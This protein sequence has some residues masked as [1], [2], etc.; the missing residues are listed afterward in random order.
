[1]TFTQIREKRQERKALIGRAE[2]L[3]TAAREATRAMTP[4]EENQFDQMMNDGDTML[5]EIEREERLLDAREGL[6]R[7]PDGLRS[8]E[9]DPPEG[10]GGSE[11]YRQA[12]LGYLRHGIEG[13]EPAQ[14]AL[15]QA[16]F[17]ELP[18][19][20]RA[21]ST[22]VTTAGGFT[23]PEEFY[24]RLTEAQLAF[25]GM[26]QSR[27]TTLETASGADLPMP[28]NNDTANKGVIVSENAQVTEQDTTFGQKVLKA[29][30][31]SSKIVRVSYQLLQDSA[32]D[33][34]G[35]LA[36]ILGTRI[37]RATNEHFTV[38][39]GTTEPEGVVTGATL[40][41]TGT[42]GQTTSVTYNDLVDLFHS[43]DP[44]YR[45]NAQWMFDDSTLK[46]LKKLVDSQN[47]PLWTPGVAV[48]EPDTILGKPYIPNTD[49]PAMAADAKSI[50]F[51][52]LSL[53]MIRDVKGI[54]VLRLTERYADYLQVG[55]LAFSRHDGALLDAGTAPVKYYANSAT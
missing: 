51:G 48:R 7:T 23:V 41:K 35:F 55:F 11:E 22:G 17:G 29:F 21:L 8:A 26:R 16:H 13:I 2:A 28:T 39:A 40:G 14:R 54:Q 33:L 31:Y 45:L 34:E 37:S 3:V 20:A 1:M 42:T 27:T 18:P 47:R 10:N 50:L 24:R 19:E 15:M 46:A 12:F 38:G 43:V 5:R 6:D 44:A 32:F 30:M 36:R 4:E 25:G 49:I 52:D 9:E 53:Y